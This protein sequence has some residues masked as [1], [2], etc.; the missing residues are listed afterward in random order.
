MFDGCPGESRT[1]LHDGARATLEFQ[2]RQRFKRDKRTTPGALA[3]ADEHVLVLDIDD[4]PPAT[5]TKQ[6]N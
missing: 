1:P 4:E 5:M 2:R 3:N 6:A